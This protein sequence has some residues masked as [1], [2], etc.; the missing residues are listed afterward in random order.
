MVN[1]IVY[2]YTQAL[3]MYANGCYHRVLKAHF[4]LVFIFD[5]QEQQV[6]TN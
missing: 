1:K 3:V 2:I 5:R 4:L 6:I